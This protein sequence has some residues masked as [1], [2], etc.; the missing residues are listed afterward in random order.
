MKAL[1]YEQFRGVLTMKD[2]PVPEA[3]PG[4]AVIKV[5]ATGLCRSDW[6]GWMGHDPDI[7]LPHVPGHEWAG[8]IEDVGRDVRNFKA[9]DRVT[10]PF[11]C[12]C[13]SCEQCASGNH[14]VCDNQTQPGFTHFGS[15]AEYVYIDYADTNLVKL[16]PQVDDLTAAIL[17]CRFITSYRAVVAQGKV[18]G[19]DYVAVHG[20]GG[21]GLSAIMIA[22]ALG[23]RVL[24]IDIREDTLALAGELGADFTVN[25]S[26]EEDV[27]SCLENQKQ[28]STGKSWRAAL[29][30][31]R[32][33]WEIR[34]RQTDS[35]Q[36]DRNR[37]RKRNQSY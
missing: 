24:A 13:G 20:C 14:Q 9:G 4:G 1:V 33:P 29:S 10:A 22:R 2:I 12:G 26:A 3:K 19:G 25:A 11:V 37:K 5:L 15:F 30:L 17:G 27:E 16:P 28:F 31:V 36:N 23:A 8:I 18:S 7:V 34:E 32:T 6:H 21:V 35:G